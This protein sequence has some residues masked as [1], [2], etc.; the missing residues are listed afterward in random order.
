MLLAQ[1]HPCNLCHT[2]ACIV[3]DNPPLSDSDGPW[4]LRR[5][6]RGVFVVQFLINSRRHNR[7]VGTIT[8]QNLVLPV[9]VV[10]LGEVGPVV[11]AAGFGSL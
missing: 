10:H 7:F 2:P 3:C 4:Y 9:F 8:Q 11:D 1:L 6:D 5:N